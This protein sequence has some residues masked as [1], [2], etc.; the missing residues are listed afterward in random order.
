[1]NLRL[2]NSLNYLRAASIVRFSRP[3]S[4][5]TSTQNHALSALLFSLSLCSRLSRLEAGSAVS[6]RQ[7]CQKQRDYNNGSWF[8]PR[9][10]ELT[11]LSD[12]I[13]IKIHIVAKHLLTRGQ[14]RLELSPHALVAFKICH[15]Y[16]STAKRSNGGT[17]QCQD[18][19]S[20]AL[21][22]RPVPW[23]HFRT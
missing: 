11:T 20:L 10:A 2:N 13:Q 18:S 17:T 6:R 15:S 22:Y 8:I 19:T 9:K 1:M 12:F 21:L 23:Q 4:V 7:Q 16:V 5:S 14:I 3:V